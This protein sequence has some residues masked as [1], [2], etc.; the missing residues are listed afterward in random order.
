MK[1]NFRKLL[2][3]FGLSVLSFPFLCH[4]AAAAE[5]EI[6]KSNTIGHLI[7]LVIEILVKYSFEVM[8]GIIILI[9]AAIIGKFTAQLVANAMIKK[10]FDVTVS[11]FVGGVIKII[12]MIF[13]MIMALGKFGI[14]IAPLI[15]GLSVA[16]VGIS[17]ALQ[18]VLSN[19]AAGIAL[20]FTKPFKVGDIIEVVNEVGEVEDMTLPRTI[21]RTVDGT[22]IYIPNKHIVGEIIHNYS[23][24][25]LLE[26]KVGIGYESD[27]KKAIDIVNRVIKNERRIPA[28]KTTKIGISEFADSSINIYARTWA[29]QMDYWDVQFA[30]HEAV[31]KE[32]R[33][34]NIEIP[35]PQRVIH[36]KTT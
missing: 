1:N 7:D 18:G 6:E 3:L 31:I 35:F 11:K 32:F 14:E 36:T 12:I 17:L 15:A 21:L 20:V 16:G 33:E 13:A 26:F 2:I 25:K 4:L 28:S 5:V 27:I 22:A 8:G 9:V 23:D 24:Y 10:K 29:K 30:I 19:Y 34:H